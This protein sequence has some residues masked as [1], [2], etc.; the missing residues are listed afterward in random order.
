MSNSPDPHAADLAARALRSALAG[1][2]DE[3]AATVTQLLSNAT[4]VQDAVMLWVNTL[5]AQSSSEPSRLLP[6]ETSALARYSSG[7]HQPAASSIQWAIEIISA[8]TSGDRQRLE[9][10]LATLHRHEPDAAPGR[11]TALVTLLASSMRQVWSTFAAVDRAGAIAARSVVVE[12]E[13]AVAGLCPVS[14]VH[15]DPE[16]EQ[17]AQAI[18]RTLPDLARSCGSLYS[19]GGGND[20]SVFVFT[21][22]DAAAAAERF[23]AAAREH[24]R[25]WWRITPTAGPVGR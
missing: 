19:R 13:L 8:Q 10:L 5:G 15:G 4:H 11:L 6:P 14:I 21:G 24:A 16:T 17:D 3:L 20:Y 23:M 1:R 25:S 18:Y 12:A 2:D 9:E 7:A 22:D